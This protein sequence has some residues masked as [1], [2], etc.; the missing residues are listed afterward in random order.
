M[1][2]RYSRTLLDRDQPGLSHSHLGASHPH[3]GVRQLAVTDNCAEEVLN[4]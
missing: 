1:D 4:L 3:L 2:D